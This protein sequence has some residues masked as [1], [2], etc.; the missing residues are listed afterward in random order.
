MRVQLTAWAL[1]LGA[2]LVGQP[3][4]AQDR[5]EAAT[6]VDVYADE[7][8]TVVSPATRVV[9]RPT[10]SVEVEMRYS[11]D[12]VSGATHAYTVD[13]V[14]SATLFSEE[15]HQVVASGA[16]E[17][18]P[19]W[20]LGASYTGSLEPD[21]VA[22]V[23]GLSMSGEVLDRMVRIRGSYRL[24]LADLGLVTD[25]QFSQR[26]ATHILEAQ[27]THILDA[28]TV[29][30]LLVSGDLAVCDELTGCHSSPYRYVPVVVD[31]GT[32]GTTQVAVRERHPDARLRGAA[33]ARISHHIGDGW[34]AHGGYRFY[35][36]SWEVIGHTFDAALAKELLGGD[37]LLRLDGR[38]TWH[39]AAA[40][41]RPTYAT[42]A[43]SAR[44]PAYRTGDREMSGLVD[45]TVG[46]RAEWALGQLGPLSQLRISGRVARLW[47]RYPR[48]EALPER[49]A[50]LIGGGAHAI[51]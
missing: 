36:D 37:L 51:F 11:A 26:S 32:P 44:I 3:A 18:A 4:V 38:V 31:G 1:A 5:L 15:R 10:E 41:F 9:G 39:S 35:G 45:G 23:P 16:L 25:E 20:W 2:S 48:F 12:V 13:A 42:A 50:W 22:H 34:A 24:E 19:T 49:N 40:F 47:Y 29:L 6:R 28:R 7:W 46:L 33:A 17:V 14:T 27:W 21:A 43:T 30:A 8:I